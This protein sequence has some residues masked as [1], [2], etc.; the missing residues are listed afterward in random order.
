MTPEF[1]EFLKKRRL[2]PE[3]DAKFS[4]FTHGFD[5]DLSG[6]VFLYF[7]RL[8]IL[9]LAQLGQDQSIKSEI[10]VMLNRNDFNKFYEEMTQIKRMIDND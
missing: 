4:N 6:T 9:N 3:C 2:E 8:E 7:D 10:A 1:E 5:D